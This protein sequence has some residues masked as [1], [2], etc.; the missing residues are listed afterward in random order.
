[1]YEPFLANNS[2]QVVNNGGPAGVEKLPGNIAAFFTEC[3]GCVFNNG[4]YKTHSKKSSDDWI[5]LIGEYYT[6]YKNRILPFGFDWMGRQY[7]VDTTSDHNL[8]MFDPSTGEVFELPQSIE[9][10][11]NSELVNDR[12]SILSEDSFNDAINILNVKFLS[13][14]SCLGYKV[15][16][17]L[18]GKD[19][20]NNYEVA[21]LEVYW[22]IQGQIFSQVKDLP[23]GTKINSIKFE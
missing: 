16:L 18:G 13:Y 15:P 4:S 21:D 12:D 19:D 5:S 9:A 23:P 6:D 20:L 7:A 17:F 14:E 22:S 3:G 10:F 2:R 1:M 11:H 8:L